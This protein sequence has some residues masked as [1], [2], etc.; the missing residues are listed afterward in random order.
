MRISVTPLTPKLMHMP[1]NFAQNMNSF[2]KGSISVDFP[3]K[4][5]TLSSVALSTGKGLMHQ[6]SH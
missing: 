5:C 6:L 2:C 4:C 3:D 1:H